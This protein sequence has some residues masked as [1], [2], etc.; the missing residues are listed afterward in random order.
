MTQPVSPQFPAVW[1]ASG[2]PRR[3]MLLEQIGLS[4]VVRTSEVEE[5]RSPE[6]GPRAYTLRLAADKGRAVRDSLSAE[7]KE[8]GP[9]WLIAADTIVV[10]RE[11]ILEKPVDE[12]DARAMIRSLQGKSHEVVTAFWVGS[13]DG[14]REESVAVSTGVRF[15]SMSEGEIA[16]YVATGEPMDKA[17]GYGIQGFAGAFVEG[18]DGCYF[19]VVGLPI[20][21]LVSVM[22]ELGALEGFPWKQE[23]A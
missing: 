4:P 22:K 20:E 16:G 3:R 2:S 6:E 8:S 10:D 5:I 7:E 21:A 11:K 9:Q 14:S 19:N 12:E 18:I 13:V 23:G 15:R 17:G 1:L